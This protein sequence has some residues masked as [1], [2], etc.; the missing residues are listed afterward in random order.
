M[1]ARGNS[2]IAKVRLLHGGMIIVGVGKEIKVAFELA[3]RMAVQVVIGWG[4]EYG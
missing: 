4:H 3:E 1:G 2:K